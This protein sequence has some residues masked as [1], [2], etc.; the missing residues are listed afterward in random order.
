MTM[1]DMSSMYIVGYSLR[2]TKWQCFSFVAV[3]RITITRVMADISLAKRSLLNN[4]SKRAIMERSNSRSS[5]IGEHWQTNQQNGCFTVY[6]SSRIRFSAVKCWRLSA[7]HEHFLGYFVLSRVPNVH[8]KP[9]GKIKNSDDIILLISQLNVFI[10]LNCTINVSISVWINTL[11]SVRGLKLC[12]IK[13][14]LKN[15]LLF[16]RKFRH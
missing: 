13:G 4:P 2:Y 3:W 10:V 16:R 11:T 9:A 12:Q 1:P 15:Y 5:C 6:R 7:L 14:R 8:D